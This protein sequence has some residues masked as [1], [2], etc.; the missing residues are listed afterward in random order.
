MALKA[1]YILTETATNLRRNFLLA[2]ATIVVVAVSLSMVGVVLLVREAVG[3]FTKRWEDGV[4]FI[5]FMNPTATQEQLDA[6]EVELRSNP[7]VAGYVF[8]DKE[9]AYA[10]FQTMFTSSDVFVDQVTP[11][12]L[13]TSFRVQPEV[14][15]A[16]VVQVL[17][18]S[19]KS[20]PGVTKVVF[21]GD[22]VRSLQSL[23]NRLT[24]AMVI[25]ATVLL[26]SAGVLI[27]TTIQTVVY[28]RRQ[29]IEVMKLVGATNWFIRVPFMLEGMLQGLF[30]A[31]LASGG[32]YFVFKAEFDRE[33]DALSSSVFETLVVGSGEA[34]VIIVV[35]IAAGAAL[36]T[37]CSAIASSWF[38]DV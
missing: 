4:E 15:D 24:T 27:F 21:A 17:S 8:F 32:V 5:V 1:D 9:D 13:P 29:E 25:A 2:I 10:E 37:I 26:V 28:S 35:L 18:D 11:E 34:T 19:F 36:G 16:D 38:L 3:N 30:G 12:Q 7:Q 31:L 20:S 6:L 33:A 14:R 22:A 23:F